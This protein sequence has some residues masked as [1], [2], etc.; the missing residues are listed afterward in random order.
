MRTRPGS[1]DQF[2]ATKNTAP[3]ASSTTPM[4]NAFQ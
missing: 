4:I 3:A 2:A 1:T